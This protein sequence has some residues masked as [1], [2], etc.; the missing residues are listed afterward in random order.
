MSER[1]T[2]FVRQ[3]SVVRQMS[4]VKQLMFV[5]QRMC[6]S[7][8]D[9]PCLSNEC[10]MCVCEWERR[11]I[12]MYHVGERERTGVCVCVH[13]CVSLFYTNVFG[14]QKW[15]V[16]HICYLH[17]A[18]QK[19]FLSSIIPAFFCR[20]VD[21]GMVKFATRKV[22]DLNVFIPWKLLRGFNIIS[23]NFLGVS[24]GAWSRVRA[25]EASIW[26]WRK[27]YVAVASSGES[28]FFFKGT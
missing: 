4:F 15:R 25:A 18:T 19:F 11:N 6:V 10:T 24:T 20:H 22:V 21:K 16:T 3:I 23:R 13:A 2:L 26:E 9:E 1:Q 27:W 8:M 14:H 5:S 28:W 12:W 17:M 7:H